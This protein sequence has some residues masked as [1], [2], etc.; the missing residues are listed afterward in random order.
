MSWL[1]IATV[2]HAD[3]RAVTD[4]APARIGDIAVDARRVV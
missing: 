2:C 3:E 1:R 4:L